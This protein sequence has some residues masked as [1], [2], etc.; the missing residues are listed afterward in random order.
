MSLAPRN[1]V[2]PVGV[3]DESI[4]VIQLLAADLILDTIYILY[5][6]HRYFYETACSSIARVLSIMHP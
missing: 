2:L 6:L 4:V 1:E 3:V 5:I